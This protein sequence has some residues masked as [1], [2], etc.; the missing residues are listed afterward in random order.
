METY[1]AAVQYDWTGLVSDV[2]Q[3]AIEADDGESALTAQFGPA[4]AMARE[5]ASYFP[6]LARSMSGRAG[7][8]A[9]IGTIEVAQ[10]LRRQGRG[11]ALVVR[12]LDEMRDLGIR[13]VYL[14]ARPEGPDF[15]EAL[16][17]FYERLGFETDDPDPAL[18]DAVYRLDL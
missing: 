13:S 6:D 16:V 8:L 3:L 14:H 10:P 9:Y 11:T 1:A 15:A 4:R 5:M 7:R 2:G 18:G 17:R 12:A